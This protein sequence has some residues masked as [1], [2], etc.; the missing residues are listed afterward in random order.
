MAAIK[1][2]IGDTYFAWGGPTANGSAAYFRVQGPAVVIEYARITTRA[3][4]ASR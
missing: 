1:E 4:P 2:K 3:A